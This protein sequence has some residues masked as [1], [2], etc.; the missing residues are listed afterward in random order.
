MT[1][2]SP[3]L[4]QRPGSLEMPVGTSPRPRFHR[5]GELRLRCNCVT[6]ILDVLVRMNDSPLHHIGGGHYREVVCCFICNVTLKYCQREL[7]LDTEGRSPCF[8]DT[9]SCVLERHRL[10]VDVYSELHRGMLY[11]FESRTPYGKKVPQRYS[12][13]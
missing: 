3:L 4:W 5:L 7:G 9:S 10:H 13:A 11:A 2:N 12:K 1:D 8:F 6:H